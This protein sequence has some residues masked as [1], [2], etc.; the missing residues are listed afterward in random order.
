MPVECFLSVRVKNSQ[1]A[2]SEWYTECTRS[3][4]KDPRKAKLSGLFRFGVYS[5]SGAPGISGYESPQCLGPLRQGRAS[6]AAFDSMSWIKRPKRCQDENVLLFAIEK[7]R[8]RPK[9]GQLPKFTFFTASFVSLCWTPG[10]T[11][12]SMY[13]HRVARRL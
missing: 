10:F 8:Q 13:A 7:M 4:E 9:S 5:D 2:E 3:T 1:R 6:K 12:V 11:R